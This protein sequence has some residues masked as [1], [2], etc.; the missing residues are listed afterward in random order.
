MQNSLLILTLSLLLVS[1]GFSLRG[2]QHNQA[3]LDQVEVYVDFTNSN[4]DYPLQQRFQRSLSS[5]GFV[6]AGAQ[7]QLKL[8]LI[9][10]R[11]NRSIMSLDSDGE[12]TR[13]LLEARVNARVSRASADKDSEAMVQALRAQEDYPVSSNSSADDASEEAIY[14][15]LDSDLIN[16]AADLLSAVYLSSQAQ[17]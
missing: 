2:Y 14:L 10:W 5:R 9:G 1:C 16:Q 17:P 4:F 7:S 11:R 15:R 12:V 6:I 13:Y 8:E 3:L